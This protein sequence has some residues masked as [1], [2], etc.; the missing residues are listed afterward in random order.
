M[1]KN[2]AYKFRLY[3]DDKQEMF[4]KQCLGSSR[5]VFNHF[6]SLNKELYEKEHRILKYNEMAKLLLAFKE[7]NVFLKD[8]DS[9]SLQ[10]ALRHLDTAYQNYFK[11]K[12]GLPQFKKKSK[13]RDSYTTINVNNNIAIIDNKHIKLPK[14]GIVK[15]KI[16]RDIPEDYKLKSATISSLPSG[17]YFVSFVF[18][19][20]EEEIKYDID[21]NKILGLDYSM[22]ELFVTEEQIKIN[23]QCLR[24]YRKSEERLHFLQK[25]LCRRQRPNYKEGKKASN[26]YEKLRKQIAK[27]FEH[28]KNIRLDYYNKLS[29]EI[30]NMYDIVVVEDINM[31][32]MAT[33]S[34]YNSK[35]TYDNGFGIFRRILKVKLEQ[36]GKKYI[37]VSKYYPSS[38]ICN[39]CGYKKDTLTIDERLWE[40]PNCYTIHDRDINASINLKQEGLRIYKESI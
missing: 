32:E 26:R 36:K 37:V 35:A 25:A 5:F 33:L 21:D 2:K 29:T 23:E 40:C 9:I 6:L 27:V 1:V 14:I 38:K 4:L 19:Y 13:H 30:A 34:K 24:L 12:Y 15:A 8:M 39:V 28:M 31:Q 22:K 20:N 10:Q 7:E 18:E 3:P 11:H 16:H 17:K